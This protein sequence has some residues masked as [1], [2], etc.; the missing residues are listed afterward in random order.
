MAY[1]HAY[2]ICRAASI[3]DDIERVLIDE[4][5]LNRSVCELGQVVSQAYAGQDLLLVSVL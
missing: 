4:A 5:S 3:H 2:E 1:N